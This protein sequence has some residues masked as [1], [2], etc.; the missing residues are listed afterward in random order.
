MIPYSSTPFTPSDVTAD[1]VATLP[2]CGGSSLGSVARS[3]CGR[4]S[5]PGQWGPQLPGPGLGLGLFARS[6]HHH[7]GT[8]GAAHRDLVTATKVALLSVELVEVN[9]EKDSEPR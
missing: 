5:A 8:L 9:R 3:P 6:H 2:Y 4:V 1:R 7:P